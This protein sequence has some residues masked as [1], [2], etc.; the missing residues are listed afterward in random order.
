MSLWKKGIKRSKTGEPRLEEMNYNSE[1]EMREQFLKAKPSLTNKESQKNSVTTL[2]DYFRVISEINDDKTVPIYRGQADT[3]FQLVPKL[4][5]NPWK[6]KAVEKDIFLEFKRQYGRYYNKVLSNDMDILM[7]GQHYG[8][9]TRLLDWTTN[10]LVALYFACCEKRDNDGVVF[11][12]ELEAKNRYT[13]V[14]KNVNP[15]SYKENIFIFPEVFET[16]FANQNGLFELFADPK[17]ESKS[18]IKAEIIIKAA[19]KT[20]IIKQLSSINMDPLGLFPTLDNL[21]KSIEEL[22]I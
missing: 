14:K 12:R 4:G 7:L 3:T 2:W 21:C 1:K 17:V 9:P 10:P 5:R 22:F 8:L 13:D 20:S 11:V 15:F 6:S 16:R 19:H 18:G